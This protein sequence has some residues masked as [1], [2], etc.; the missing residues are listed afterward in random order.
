[1]YLKSRSNICCWCCRAIALAS[2]F[3]WQCCVKKTNGCM[4]VS[5]SLMELF[6]T[7][8][9]LICAMNIYVRNEKEKQK[10][11]QTVT[12]IKQDING[13]NVNCSN[14]ISSLPLRHW[15][16][17]KNCVV[18]RDYQSINLFVTVILNIIHFFF[19]PILISRAA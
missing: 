11:H 16:K 18:I 10:Q 12:S 14:S 13:N 17:E 6:Q 15:R 4:C 1:M 7:N 2:S 5:D 19:P 9:A 8:F 3:L